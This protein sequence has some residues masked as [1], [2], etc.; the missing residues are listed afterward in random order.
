MTP[1]LSCCPSL[2]TVTGWEP[3]SP[4]RALNLTWFNLSGNRPIWA[5]QLPVPSALGLQD[6]VGPGLCIP[7]TPPTKGFSSQPPTW[8]AALSC[9]EGPLEPLWVPT[10]TLPQPGGLEGRRPRV[11]PG[12][13]RTL[14]D[15]PWKGSSSS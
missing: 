2:H 8:A 6:R 11:S 10:P 7:K 13:P 15:P 3:C 14:Q 12:G 1:R 5:P 4:S 9:L